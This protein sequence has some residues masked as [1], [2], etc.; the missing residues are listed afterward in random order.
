MDW[1]TR[2]A[3]TGLAE[4]GLSQ[5]DANCRR[6]WK[7]VDIEVNRLVILDV[8]LTVLRIHAVASSDSR[9]LDWRVWVSEDLLCCGCECEDKA[10]H[11]EMAAKFGDRPHTHFCKHVIALLMRLR[12]EENNQCQDGMRTVQDLDTTLDSLRRNLAKQYPTLKS[13]VAF[14]VR[15]RGLIKS[16]DACLSVADLSELKLMN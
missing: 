2:T 13:P 7:A 1:E 4:L 15:L 9:D 11:E 10:R 12:K 5:S 14:H 6:W 8:S 16:I 3:L